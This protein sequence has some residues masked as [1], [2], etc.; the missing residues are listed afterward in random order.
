MKETSGKA[1][2]RRPDAQ[3]SIRAERGRGRVRRENRKPQRQGGHKAIIT[4]ML[5]LTLSAGM[6][7][8]WLPEHPT[9]NHPVVHF[10]CRFIACEGLTDPTRPF[11]DIAQI[12]LHDIRITEHGK[13][14]SLTGRLT[15][16]ADKGQPLPVLI[17]RLYTID[18]RLVNRYAIR[19]PN[20]LSEP[21]ELPILPGETQA[22]KYTMS[23]P[24]AVAMQY[25]IRMR[26]AAAT[27]N[28]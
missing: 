18:G 24:G 11:Q 8:W 5:L 6:L 14:L 17:V 23:D 22:I 7:A 10:A 20:Y 9:T 13:K 28:I 1:N 19:P 25:N 26:N 16:N 21:T 4:V 15:N 2:A 3:P 27:I 12:S